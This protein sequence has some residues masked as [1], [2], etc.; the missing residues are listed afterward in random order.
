MEFL[1]INSD[2]KNYNVK[3]KRGRPRKDEKLPEAPKKTKKK[4]KKT[5]KEIILQMPITMSDIRGADTSPNN[6]VEE[7]SEMFIETENGG[8]K[9]S[10]N[11]FTLADITNTSSE[12]YSSCENENDNENETNDQ[13][14]YLL[15]KINER[16]Q[17]IKDLKDKLNSSKRLTNGV[18]EKKVQEMGLKLLSLD[19]K[20]ISLNKGN[21]RCWWDHN[22]FAEY[23]S[24][25]VERYHNKVYY[26][27]GC[28]CSASCALAYN[29]KYLDDYRVSE[30][31]GL[32]VQ[33]H[34]EMTGSNNDVPIAPSWLTL[35]DYGGP[36]TIESFRDNC[37]KN[38]ID[39]EISLPPIRHINYIITEKSNDVDNNVINSNDSDDLI[40]KR[41]KPL[42]GAKNTLMETMGL[43][44][45]KVSKKTKKT[46]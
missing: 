42:P 7:A 34:R 6:G 23:P 38:G 40:L 19:N 15:K 31:H 27:I 1:D 45:E 35:K 3:R 37:S 26:V 10:D 11:I 24:F 39:Y 25:I 13:V 5:T 43:T 9:N 44:M 21:C 33:L 30:R 32:T 16:D 4:E 29:I 36:L 14:K 18:N 46:K 17:I 20:K 41:S 2:D 12:E 8:V 28:F 22:D